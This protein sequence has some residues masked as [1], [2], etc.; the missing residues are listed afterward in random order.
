MAKLSHS[1]TLFFLL[2]VSILLATA[3]VFGELFKKFRQPAVIGEI[4]GGILLGPSVLGFFYPDA[5]QMLF[6]SHPNSA[7]SLNGLTSIAVIMLLF[8]AGLEV[9]LP[10]IWK[11]GRSAAMI[12]LMGMLLPFGLGFGCAW[13]AYDLFVMEEAAI[14]DRNLFAFFMAT[15]MSISAL[16]VIAKT[17]IDLKMLQT[18][19]G[20]LI[21][22]AAMV[23]DFVGWILFSII[24]SFITTSTGGFH[25]ETWQTV[26]LTIGFAVFT[27]TIVRWGINKI[28]PI[29]KKYLSWPGSALSVAM[30][31][32]FSAAFFTEFIGI[33]A[34][35]GAFLMGI[36]FGDSVHFTEKEID[37]IHEFVSNVFAPL[38][39]VTIGLKVNFVANFDLTVVALVF[40][41]AC[42][43]K[44][45]GG[46]LG[47]ILGGLPRKEALAV[48]FGIN[49][50]GAMEIILGLLALEAGLIG[51][52]VFVALVVMA[53][54]TSILS[55]PPIGY[56]MR[57]EKQAV[58]P[59][60]VS[61]A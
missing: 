42:F 4:L 9:E 23:D 26:L 30:A 15:A 44:V 58:V 57:K 45:T 61:G 41:I 24:L 6:L 38:F 18:R 10:V 50:R 40:G 5:F 31:F 55:G 46:F 54:L 21:I 48:G 37:I 47:G 35:F 36:A 32:C 29:F 3:R 39:F 51:E 60:P 43:S 2:Q 7:I 28:L 1:D 16:P 13:Y 12:S 49:A 22:A 27:L 25:F 33:H 34:I 59:P 14:Q 52:T 19:I 11:N 53:I 8:I 56:L 20:N 17:L